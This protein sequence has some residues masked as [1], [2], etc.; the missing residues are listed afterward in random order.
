[1]VAAGTV[2]DRWRAVLQLA[3]GRAVPTKSLEQFLSLLELRPI[4]G[5]LFSD[6]RKCLARLRADRRRLGAVSDAA[7]ED[8]LRA[9]L[10][11]LAV[12]ETFEVVQ[13]VRIGQPGNLPRDNIA[14]AAARLNLDPRAVLFVG[15]RAGRGM[16]GATGLG[17]ATLWLNRQGTGE[18]CFVPEILSLSELPRVVRE[19]EGGAGVK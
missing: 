4:G 14:R 17:M 15:D 2:E 12:L 9:L 5:A 6:V 10:E 8:G 11:R 13:A 18:A 1:V 19:L 7:S 3:L 16:R